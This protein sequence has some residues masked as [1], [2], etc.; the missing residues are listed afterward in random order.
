[1]TLA[2]EGDRRR[3][4]PLAL[5]SLGGIAI[6]L[7]AGLTALGI[8]QLQR[9]VWKLDLI[10]Q[11]DQR[12]HAP[13]VDAPGRSAWPSIDA[14][15]DAYRRVRVAGTF[16][17]D[18]DTLVQAVTTLGGG[19]WVMSPLRTDAGTTILVNRG[20]ISGDDKDRRRADVAPGR[21]EITGLLR[22]TEPRGGFLRSNDPAADRWHSRDVEAIAGAR[23]LADVAPYFI[24]ADAVPG[25]GPVGGLTVVSLPNSHMVY[26]LTWFALAA[27]LAGGLAYAVRTER[28]RNST[29]PGAGVR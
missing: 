11:I 23:G 18:R 8:W 12:I 15:R 20:F 21:V 1:M 25:N 3:R 7:I 22:I 29:S 24:D 14:S 26:A 9:R 2:G 16:L 13:A 4:S 28:A 27:M 19:Y 10:A 5:F 6:L 17:R